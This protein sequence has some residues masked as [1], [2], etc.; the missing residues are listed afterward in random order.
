MRSHG[1]F[2]NRIKDHQAAI[3][4]LVEHLICNQGVGGS[5]PS[6]GT[7]FFQPDCFVEAD[8]HSA[9]CPCLS[10]GCACL[11]VDTVLFEKTPKPPDKNGIKE[12]AR[13]ILGDFDPKLV[14]IIGPC[15]DCELAILI[16]IPDFMWSISGDGLS[17]GSSIQPASRNWRSNFRINSRFSSLFPLGWE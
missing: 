3:A 17:Q 6:G 2:G 7:T 15:K 13:A 9:T 14:E 12:T 5:N 4:Q 16:H 8:P 10:S 11:R 1:S